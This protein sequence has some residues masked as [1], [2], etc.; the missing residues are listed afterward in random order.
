MLNILRISLTIFNISSKASE[1][2]FLYNDKEL[3]VRTPAFLFLMVI[4][5]SGDVY[6]VHVA[7]KFTKSTPSNYSPRIFPRLQSIQCT[8]NSNTSVRIRITTFLIF[9]ASGSFSVCD[10]N[11]PH[12]AKR[13]R[14]KADKSISATSFLEEET[15]AGR[16]KQ[17][18]KR[19]RLQTFT[20]CW[21]GS[22]LNK[23]LLHF[24]M[25]CIYSYW[26]VLF[27]QIGKLYIYTFDTLILRSK[28]KFISEYKSPQ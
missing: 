26:N 5:N 18:D 14:N 19:R 27:A 13:L 11:L 10:P 25:D 16:E 8:P 7:A 22:K 2:I 3:S 23:R 6:Y 4:W 20:I 15:G 24:W 28:H 1:N 9:E 12:N 21:W 17:K